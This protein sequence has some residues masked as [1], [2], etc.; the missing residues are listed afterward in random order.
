MQK[1]LI[2]LLICFE[3]CGCGTVVLNKVSKRIKIGMTEQQIRG[4]EG[5]PL[6]RSRKIINGRTYETW[7]YDNML[8]LD[9]ID[10]ILVGYSSDGIYVSKDGQDKVKK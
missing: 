2:I 1:L 5:G 9:F 7:G 6:Q 10:T 3:L 8:T 4:I